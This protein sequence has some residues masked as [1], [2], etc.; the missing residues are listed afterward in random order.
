MNIIYSSIG[1]VMPPDSPLS[2]ADIYMHKLMVLFQSGPLAKSALNN[3]NKLNKMCS[4]KIHCWV[5]L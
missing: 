4:E 5:V 2:H 3:F 1:L